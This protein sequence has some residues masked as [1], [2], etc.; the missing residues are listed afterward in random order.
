M[1]RWCVLLA[2]VGCGSK[3]P[4]PPASFP[5][6]DQPAAQQF[7]EPDEQAMAGNAL[8]IPQPLLGVPVVVRDV[9]G[10]HLFADEQL[11]AKKLITTWARGA[12]LSVEDPERTT[13][14]FERAALGQH[15]VTGQ[16]CGAGLWQTPAAERWRAELKGRARI[17]AGVACRDRCWL[18]LEISEGLDPGSADAGRSAAYAAP[19]DV[20]KPWRT[21]LAVRLLQL[22]YRRDAEAPFEGGILKSATVDPSFAPDEDAP[23]LPP[24]LERTTRACLGTSGAVGVLVESDA[25]GVVARCESDEST[26]IANRKVVPCVCD[27]LAG[28]AVGAPGAR[29]GL[30][31][32][33]EEKAVT[34]K[35]GHAVRVVARAAREQNPTTKQYEPIV[36]TP[37]IAE[38][39]PPREWV[40]APCFA[41][42]TGATPIEARVD[43]EGDATGAVGSVH[44]SSVT[45]TLTTAMQTCV[46]QAFSA[47]KVPCPDAPTWRAT[48][49]LGVEFAQP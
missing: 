2:L 20:S 38:W 30:V 29:T 25:A 41:S 36:T 12:G 4:P 8:M 15:A 22:A 26:I 10:L 23:P 11:D 9:E 27:A 18:W 6:L 24:A 43:I 34:T 7:A 31:I 17:H 37:S 28:Q 45:G 39:E 14:I 19:Y 40:L 35:R 1:R 46:K 3:A 16:A 47:I 42:A 33:D 32:A 44:L 21:E 5:S 48:A 49:E 13:L